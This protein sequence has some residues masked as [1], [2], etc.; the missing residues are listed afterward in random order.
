M[1]TTFYAGPHPDRP[2]FEITV[3][4]PGSGW[5]YFRR[6]DDRYPDREGKLYGDDVPLF[7][8]SH[9]GRLLQLVTGLALGTDGSPNRLIRGTAG[10][11]VGIG[12]DEAGNLLPL[13][14]KAVLLAV[15]GEDRY[16]RTIATDA[17]ARQPRCVHCGAGAS[18]AVEEAVISGWC[19]EHGHTP[20]G[21][22]PFTS[23]QTAQSEYANRRTDLAWRS[24][25]D[26]DSSD[27]G[28]PRAVP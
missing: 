7:A 21:T 10:R 19:L 4:D 8:G 25:R 2:T 20:F 5:L 15:A 14:T 3:N 16:E 23:W 24:E 11:A 9:L 12:V 22:R 18:D 6:L 26:D 28:F 13:L 17:Q 1:Q 27:P